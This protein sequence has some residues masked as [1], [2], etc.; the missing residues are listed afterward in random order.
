M[1]KMQADCD[2]PLKNLQQSIQT[3]SKKVQDRITVIQTETEEDLAKY[4]K[5]KKSKIDPLCTGKSE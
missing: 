3:E 1:T 4:K 5:F 2:E